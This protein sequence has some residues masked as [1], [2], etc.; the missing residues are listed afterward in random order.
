MVTIISNAIFHRLTNDIKT[1][2]L[3]D[4]S[5]SPHGKLY[6]IPCSALIGFYLDLGEA[7]SRS[8]VR[9]PVVGEETFLVREFSPLDLG[10]KKNL[11]P[12][13]PDGSLD[14]EARPPESA[15]TLLTHDKK[16]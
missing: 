8:G 2:H 1:S 12:S 5:V 16:K 4:Y 15:W 9:R 6:S 7:P 14:V 13:F 11:G 3:K 10:E